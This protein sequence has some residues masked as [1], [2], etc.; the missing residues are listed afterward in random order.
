MGLCHSPRVHALRWLRRVQFAI[1]FKGRGKSKRFKRNDVITG[2]AAAVGERATVRVPRCC[3]CCCASC[4]MMRNVV[5]GVQCCAR[6]SL[7]CYVWQV[8]LSNPDLVV[9]IE[10][11]KVCGGGGQVC[12]STVVV[13][14]HD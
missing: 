1:M 5:R 8:D 14:W 12:L 7:V 11:V 2:V 3:C 4:A 6:C 9:M 13:C 10:S